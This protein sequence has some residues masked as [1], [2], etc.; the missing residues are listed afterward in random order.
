MN[1]NMFRASVA[2]SN[3]PPI[4]ACV[5][6]LSCLTV[7]AQAVSPN[8]TQAP[9]NSVSAPLALANEYGRLPLSFEANQGQT[10][11]RVRFTARGKGYSIFLT[12]SE[13]VLALENGD[14]DWSKNDTVRVQ[15]AGG[16]AGTK[17]A[18]EDKL[19]GV[20]NYFIGNDPA[21]WRRNV[22]IYAKVRYTSA[23][24]GVDLVYYGNQGRLEYDFIVA[25]GSDPKQ[26]KLHF[27]GAKKLKLDAEG[28]LRIIAGNGE[29]AFRKPVVYQPGDKSASQRIPVDG[30]F[31][32][33]AG[34]TVGF[35][36]GR[37]DKTRTVVIDPTW[38]YSTY[39]GGSSIDSPSDIAIDSYG[40]AYVTGY[41]V[42]TDF[43]V[44]SGAFQIVNK[45][46]A[47]AFTSN[48]FIS[49]LNSSGSAL[50]YSTYLGGSNSD[51]GNGIVVDASG[52]A[53]VTGLSFS[54][55]FPVTS[56][57]FQTTNNA[58]NGVGN[59]FIT[60]LNPSG[61]NLVYST[62]LGGSQGD[63][64][65]SIAIDNSGD[66]YVTGA[67]SSPDFPVTSGA[68]QA[69]NNAPS[70]GANAFVTE[71]NP[72]GNALVYSTYL[73]G[74]TYDFGSNIAVDAWGSA[75]VAGSAESRDFPVTP[76][77]FQTTNNS[78]YSGEANAFVAKLSAGGTA[79]VY[80]TYLGGSG[81]SS[82]YYAGDRAMG[83][84]LDGSGSA[85][86]AGVA[87]S[88]DFPVT[89]GA[90]QALNKAAGNGVS[91]AF[92]AKLSPDGS[93]LEYSTYLGGSSGDG[94]MNIAVDSSGHAYLT[95]FVNSADF[96]VTAGALQA[97]KMS[98]Q[99]SNA[100]LAK[101]GPAGSTLIYSSFLG[102]SGNTPGDFGT[103]IAVDNNGSPYVTGYTSSA[104]FPMTRRPFQSTNNTAPNGGYTGFVTRF[105]NAQARTSTVLTSDVNPQEV[106]V[107]VTFTAYVY[108]VLGTGTTGVPT[109]T[110][111]FTVDV[112][113]PV[114]VE[115]DD[116]GHASYPV[117][118]LRVGKHWIVATYSGD[119]HY[120]ASITA[121]EE[122]IQ[123]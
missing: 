92:A 62:Y 94:C 19:S 119:P 98:P 76:G 69:A 63:A 44:S 30:K 68:I 22:P 83:I 110:V 114:E 36:L 60:K 78:K 84:A 97:A 1:M 64:A 61:S 56:G 26:L 112:G 10:D 95:G 6:L 109:G 88:P 12:D 116:T 65:Y 101:L 51:S 59:A 27:T 11:Q 108:P 58:L 4:A 105:V 120:G 73:G 18:G 31:S 21:Q 55:D 77:S 45:K 80:S 8:S 72:V 43:P 48:A 13:A 117:S 70:P 100:F 91:N 102:G 5:I 54:T 90:L 93:T 38:E 87:N 121:F 14:K 20:T 23:Y 67:S 34:N 28:D 79:L 33:L 123:P 7:S 39:L 17:V 115:L 9:V 85:Y 3:F 66:A 2:A 104:D 50:I 46:S 118:S 75:Y 37:Y 41:T 42:S 49:K 74:H 89:P 15:I 122:V 113:T 16:N 35:K 47:D 53:Y 25:P 40:N 96:P 111:A 71:L 57:A 103:G 82:T 106:G 99:G 107:T 29:I 52:S 32:L 81:S 86:V 24:P